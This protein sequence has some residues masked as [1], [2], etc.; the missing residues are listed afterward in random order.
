M[1]RNL[2][3]LIFKENNQ[4]REIIP[5]PEVETTDMERVF[6]EYPKDGTMDAKNNKTGYI[7]VWDEIVK[8]QT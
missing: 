4:F 3:I 2:H 8:P 1:K 6:F 5:M 7:R